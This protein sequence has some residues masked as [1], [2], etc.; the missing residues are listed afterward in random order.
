M[1]SLAVLNAISMVYG[2]MGRPI[3]PPTS[4]ELPNC[5]GTRFS[6]SAEFDRDR[7]GGL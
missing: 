4:V 3:A 6:S 5:F 2:A 1:L 7:D